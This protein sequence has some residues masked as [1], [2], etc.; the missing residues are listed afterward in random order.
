MKLKYIILYVDDVAASLGTYEAAFGLTCRFL[1]EAGD[2]GELETGQ[3]VLAFSAKALMRDLGKM[4]GEVSAQRPTFELAFEVEDVDAA[5]AQ[6]VAAGAICTQAPQEQPWGQVTSYVTMPDGYL[7][8][9]CS[10]VQVPK[11]D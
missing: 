6:A 7:V 1:H 3:T 4:P 11:P 9:I 2:Y 8:E 5:L 10:A